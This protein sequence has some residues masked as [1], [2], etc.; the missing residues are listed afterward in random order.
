METESY[1]NQLTDNE[2]IN[3]IEVIKVIYLFHKLCSIKKFTAAIQDMF[4]LFTL[5]KKSP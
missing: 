5:E 4:A 2:V 3:I 1:I